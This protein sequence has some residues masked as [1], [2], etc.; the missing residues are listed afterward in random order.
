MSQAPS[1]FARLLSKL[2]KALSTFS[3]R[4]HCHEKELGESFPPFRDSI[5]PNPLAANQNKA[6]VASQ[7]QQLLRS[8]DNIEDFNS[9][10]VAFEQSIRW[11]QTTLPTALLRTTEHNICPIFSL[12]L[13]ILRRRARNVWALDCLH[14]SS[15]LVGLENPSVEVQ[16]MGELLRVRAS[17]D[18]WKGMAECNTAVEKAVK[19][20]APAVEV[21]LRLQQVQISH[22]LDITLTHGSTQLDTL[23]PTMTSEPASE[24]LQKAV[25]ICRR[26]PDTAGKFGGLVSKIVKLAS[27][28][29]YDKEG[30]L[31]RCASQLASLPQSCTYETRR[32]ELAWGEFFGGSVAV[33]ELEGHPYSMEMGGS[34]R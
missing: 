2:G 28:Q 15:Y 9:T 24:S 12:R 11:I 7:A 17:K 19:A 21:E 18:C 34:R 23:V 32:T 5:R 14:V 3:R 8:S 20:K 13:T 6:L 33:C 22:L 10:A 27:G 30:T 29:R 26:F 16:C 1:V 31:Q 25:Q 4:V